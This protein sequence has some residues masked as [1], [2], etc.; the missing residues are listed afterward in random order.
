MIKTAYEKLK[1]KYKLPSFDALNNELE[2]S[3]IESE[4]FLLRKIRKKIAERIEIT[5]EPISSLLQPSADSIIDMH[6]CRFF[7]DKDKKKMVEIYK[8]LMIL[9]RLSLEAEMS[10]DDKTDANFINDFFKQWPE[11]K[12]DVL[13]F[14][15]KMKSC[16]EKE[17]EIEEKLEYFG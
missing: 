8:K 14:I 17:T 1:K 9:G 16:W 7:T 15:K 3:E 4:D 5:A 11:L 6:E 12:K 13:H 10:G 2:I